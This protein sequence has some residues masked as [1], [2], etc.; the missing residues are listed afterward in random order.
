MKL[1]QR[2]LWELLPG[3][4]G[5]QELKRRKSRDYFAELGARGGATTRDR[6]GVDYLKEL[7][8]R[9]GEANRKR[10]H[11]EPRT[12][13]P[14]YG[15]TERR[16]PYWPPKRTKR[17]KR[18]IYVRVELDEPEQQQTTAQE[19]DMELPSPDASDNRAM[20]HVIYDKARDS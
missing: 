17:R 16:V 19:A 5:G 12:I 14:W 2:E 1:E 7:G 10:Y 9:G 20:E 6:Y 13:H 3:A 15:G 8:Q 18:P 4:A 11:D